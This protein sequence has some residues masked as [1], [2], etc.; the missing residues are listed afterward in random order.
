MEQI[1]KIIQEYQ[2]RYNQI[3]KR[4]EKNGKES[5]LISISLIAEFK[6]ELIAILNDSQK[7]KEIDLKEFWD[8]LILRNKA[9]YQTPEMQ[10]ILME[11]YLHFQNE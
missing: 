4:Y 2:D 1:K 8:Y 3:N 7:M 10:E 11:D 9:T 6:K 5:H